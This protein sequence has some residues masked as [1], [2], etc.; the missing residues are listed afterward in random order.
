MERALRTHTTH[1]PALGGDVGNLAAARTRLAQMPP[2]GGGEGRATEDAPPAHPSL[3]ATAALAATAVQEDNGHDAP[4]E[5]TGD[6]GAPPSWFSWLT[7]RSR[8]PRPGTS[9]PFGGDSR[10]PPAAPPPLGQE[11]FARHITEDDLRSW[12]AFY[13]YLS[14]AWQLQGLRFLT[15]QV[16][17]MVMTVYTIRQVDEY[18]L[19]PACVAAAHVFEA[20]QALVW[21]AL[22]W[23]A[24]LPALNLLFW[25]TVGLQTVRTWCPWIHDD[26]VL[27]P[28]QKARP[29][30][31]LHAVG[32]H[33]E[34]VVWYTRFLVPNS[35]DGSRSHGAL[36]THAWPCSCTVTGLVTTTL[37]GA[38]V[39]AAAG[40]LASPTASV[41]T[42]VLGVGVL[43]L[44]LG[45]KLLVLVLEASHWVSDVLFAAAAVA[46]AALVHAYTA[47]QLPARCLA[48]LPF[49]APAAPG[50]P[51]RLQELLR[52]LP[53]LLPTYYLLCAL[54]TV[55]WAGKQLAHVGHNSHV[56]WR[57]SATSEPDLRG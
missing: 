44:G 3:S 52:L 35:M 43:V 55:T 46:L 26:A 39:C 14:H 50:P 7:G 8:P 9:G 47:L 33:P 12:R 40:A 13:T 19:R 49:A 36:R 41:V 11:P 34:P 38:W 57:L 51:G 20:G 48:G 37:A 31:Q 54:I 16:F 32:L 10:S 2:G 25:C 15:A 29:W 27:G 56:L 23:S 21:L 6:S 24:P 17:D 42:A 45:A 18:D 22:V 30:I 4:A 28:L 53:G 1:A 5:D